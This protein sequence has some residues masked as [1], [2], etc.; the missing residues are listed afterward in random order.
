MPRRPATT[1]GTGKAR[2]RH[3]QSRSRTGSAVTSVT[4][5]S[6]EETVTEETTITDNGARGEVSPA[7]MNLAAVAAAVAVYA[8]L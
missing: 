7:L 2:H 8:A 4:T 3:D 6:V 5:R 1:D